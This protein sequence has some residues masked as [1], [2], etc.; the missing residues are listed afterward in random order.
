V[1]RQERLVL[2]Y[3]EKT[4]TEEE[5]KKKW[6]PQ[7]RVGFP[8]SSLNRFSDGDFPQSS[9]CIGSNC[10]AWRYFPNN[11]PRDEK[12]HGYC[13]LAGKDGAP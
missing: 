5:A 13:G 8:K 10:M 2:G 6:C 9:N 1:S 4:M 3:G 11:V 12:P 7:S